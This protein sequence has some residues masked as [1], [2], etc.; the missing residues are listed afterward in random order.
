MLTV[1][2]NAEN[3]EISMTNLSS[4]NE[5]IE[6]SC[7]CFNVKTFKIALSKSKFSECFNGC[8]DVGDGCWR[9]NVLMTSLR[10]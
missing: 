8:M 2:Y 9:P 6:R 10:C 4:Q 5:P 3:D 1:R 7:G